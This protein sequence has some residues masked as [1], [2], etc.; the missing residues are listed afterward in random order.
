M[1]TPRQL[2][3]AFF[4]ATLQGTEVTVALFATDGLYEVPYL[5][6]LGLPWRYRGRDEI[7]RFL[8]VNRE[9]FPQL[10]FHDLV[11]VAESTDRVVAEYQFTTRSTRTARMIHQLIV[12]QLESA[13]GRIALLRESVNLVEMALALYPHGLAD[14]RV[15]SD[16]DVGPDS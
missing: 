8:A 2:L 11:I 6:S 4:E 15:P 5:E 7:A 10:A 13:G 12:G 9:L 14:H 3:N 16:R 1:R